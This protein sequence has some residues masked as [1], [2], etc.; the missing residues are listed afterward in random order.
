MNNLSSKYMNDKE[1]LDLTLKSN[2]ENTWVRKQIY[3]Q[4]NESQYQALLKGYQISWDM[5]YGLYFENGYFYNY[6]SGVLVGK[7]KVEQI[8]S[9]MYQVAEIYDNPEKN[10]WRVVFD[11]LR[12]ACYQNNVDLDIEE[13]IEMRTKN[14]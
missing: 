12:E 14:K 11:S 8:E 5:R 1:L 7:F 2:T 13:F 3:L 9:G 4:F 10:D 6:R